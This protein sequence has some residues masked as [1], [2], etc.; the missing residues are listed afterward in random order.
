MDDIPALCPWRIL[1]ENGYRSR[2]VQVSQSQLL[3]R[4]LGETIV[5]HKMQ[6]LNWT[7]KETG[8]FC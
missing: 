2:G 8:L 7:A 1:S 3:F 5:N 6:L 4:I